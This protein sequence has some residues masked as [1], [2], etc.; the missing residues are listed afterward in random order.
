MRRTERALHGDQTSIG[1]EMGTASSRDAPP[2]PSPTRPP[3]RAQIES[4]IDLTLH[5]NSFTGT[6]YNRSRDDWHVDIEGDVRVDAEESKTSLT[7]AN[8]HEVS[9]EYCRFRWLRGGSPQATIEPDSLYNTSGNTGTVYCSSCPCLTDVV[10]F[11]GKGVIITVSHVRAYPPPNRAFAC[12]SLSVVT[13][14]SRFSRG[15]RG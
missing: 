15:P 4:D 8:S 11:V 7:V 5:I 1:R 3:S 9:V 13:I 12:V 14:T 2:P 10:P 6:I